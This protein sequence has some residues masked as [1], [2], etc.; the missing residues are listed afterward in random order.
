V[1]GE[2]TRTHPAPFPK[3]LALRLIS[4]FSFV[5]DVVLDPFW[6]MGNTT[7]AA[8]ETHRSSI[9][10]EIEP[11][12]IR[13]GRNRFSRLRFGGPR[14]EFLELAERPAPNAAT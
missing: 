3:E 14:V 10:F 2:S 6:G 11:D 7:A 4:M 13:I 1:P 9:G 12:V 5:G 8:I